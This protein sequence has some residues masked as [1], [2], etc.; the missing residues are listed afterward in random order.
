MTGDLHVMPGGAFLIQGDGT[1]V[2][3][4]EREYDTEDLLQKL[5]ADYPN[6]L[7]GNQIA[8][9]DPRRWLLLSREKAIPGEE[10]GAGRWSLDHLFVDQDGTPTL[11]EVKRASDTRTRREVV[12]QMLDYAA[13][14]VV[15]WRPGEL[16]DDFGA[17]CEARGESPDDVLAQFLQDGADPGDFWERVETNLRAGRIRVLFVADQIPA[18]LQRVVEFLNEQMDPAE[19]LAV[20]I[21]QYVGGG[22]KALFP[23]VMGQTAEAGQ[24][25]QSGPRRERQWDEESFIA[26]LKERKGIGAVAVAQR[27]IAWARGRGVEVRWGR[28]KADGSCVLLVEAAGRRHHSIILWTYGRVE[29]LFGWMKRPFDEDARREE[30]RRRL[31]LITGVALPEDSLARR[32]AFPIDALYDPAALE[33]FIAV[34]DWVVDEI[35]AWAAGHEE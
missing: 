23:R 22:Q 1:L 14:A 5:L 13:N 33:Q 26:D 19:V 2:E 10:D 17:Q 35:E 27:V 8:P 4:S 25:K 32:P 6:L 16:A 11:V 15:Y 34:L 18:E 20:E 21:R 7:A 31:N 3:M 30:F 24:R 9:Q 29:V 28:G 12:A